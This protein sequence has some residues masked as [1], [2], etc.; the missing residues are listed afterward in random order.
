MNVT[1]HGDGG[2]ENGSQGG[3]QIE[4]YDESEDE[5][6]RVRGGE[7][8]ETRSPGQGSELRQRPSFQVHPGPSP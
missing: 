8:S 2:D 6:S 5:L 3:I 4:R 1:N 7:T